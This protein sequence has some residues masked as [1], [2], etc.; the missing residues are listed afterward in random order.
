MCFVLDG[1]EDRLAN[2]LIAGL[3]S[4]TDVLGIQGVW[5][6]IPAVLIPWQRHAGSQLHRT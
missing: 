1:L 5:G 6:T 4:S 3:S 2:E